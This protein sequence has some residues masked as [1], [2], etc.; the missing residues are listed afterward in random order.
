MHDLYAAIGQYMLYVTEL[1]RREADRTLYLAVPQE[2]YD[3]IF[4]L[5]HGRRLREDWNIR[6]IVYDPEVEEILQW[7]E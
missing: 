2:I 7:I 3:N 6:L 5:P 1:R 4:D